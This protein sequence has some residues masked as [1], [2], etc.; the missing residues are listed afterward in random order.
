MWHRF[1]GQ[2]SGKNIEIGVIGSDRIF[3]WSSHTL[4]LY[5]YLYLYLSLYICNDKCI[6]VLLNLSLFM[7]N[8]TGHCRVLSPSEIDD[9]LAEVEW[10][11]H[12]PNI[13]ITI[14]ILLQS[15]QNLPV[16]ISTHWFD[17]SNKFALAKAELELFQLFRYS[18]Y[19]MFRL[20]VLM[21][22]YTKLAP[23]VKALWPIGCP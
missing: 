22:T 12:T 5:L 9:Y 2:I 7:I 13:W 1:E 17:F 20:R 11:K 15:P 6:Y 3:R 16:L 18:C 8:M 23:L 19:L 4:Y 14:V 10:S 21:F